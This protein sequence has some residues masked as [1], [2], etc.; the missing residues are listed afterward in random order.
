[1][2]LGA[3]VS[4]KKPFSEAVIRASDIG[5]E[6]M[7]IFVNAQKR[8]NP[9]EIDRSELDKFV[10]LNIEKD[11]K[12]VIIHSIYLI[13]LA[14]SNPFYLES[15]I[16]SL[17]DDME[18]AEKVGALGVNFHV[19]STKGAEFSEVLPKVVSAIKEILDK[20]PKEPYLILENSA[21]SGNIIGDTIEEL[22]EIIDA[23]G[24][25]RLKITL[26]TAHALGSGYDIKSKEG[27]DQLLGKIDK[28]MELDRLVC[29]HLND[30]AVELNSKKDRHAD[31]GEGFIGKDAFEYIVN[32]PKLKD[33]C[34]IIETPSNKGKGDIDNIKILKELRK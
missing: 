3:H 25:D 28:L 27:F 12:P 13:N 7:Q 19:G 14:S 20:S 15:S 33:V 11:I 9:V 6:C 17:V 2:R 31:I 10:E 26:D 4:T 24:S 16:K 30:S 1:M 21:G 18:K 8:W 5:C 34:G 32:H 23:V 29:L 22:A